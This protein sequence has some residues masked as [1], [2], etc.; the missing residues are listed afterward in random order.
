MANQ[1]RA[2][3]NTPISHDDLLDKARD[4]AYRA[5]EALT[6][7]GFDCSY[8]PKD[9]TPALKSLVDAY[10]KLSG[11]VEFDPNS[12]ESLPVLKAINNKNGSRK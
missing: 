11:L 7:I 3:K 5:L 9:R 1:L 10:I 6:A 8:D 4:G 2:V 12:I